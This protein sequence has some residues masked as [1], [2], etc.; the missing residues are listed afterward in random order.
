MLKFFMKRKFTPGKSFGLHII[1]G[2]VSGSMQRKS[3]FWPLLTQQTHINPPESFYAET[4]SE[5][6][7]KIMFFFSFF[8]H[9]LFT[10]LSYS[11]FSPP[12]HMIHVS[13]YTHIL[14]ICIIYTHIICI[15]IIHTIP[16]T[17]NQIQS[18][19]NN[20]IGFYTHGVILY[21]SPDSKVFYIASL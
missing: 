19:W 21:K 3:R 16:T 5:W 15:Y 9:P 4:M 1:S 13:I 20:N 10:P 18:K 7:A 14:Y 2:H 8:I 6:N 11:N 12:M 17:L